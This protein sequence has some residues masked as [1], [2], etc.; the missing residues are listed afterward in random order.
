MNQ[1]L[2]SSMEWQII[3][4]LANLLAPAEQ[5]T[6]LLGGE[7]YTTLA[8]T[9]PIIEEVIQHFKNIKSS[10]MTINNMRNVILNDLISRWSIPN[11]FGTIASFLDPRFKKLTFCS[12]VSIYC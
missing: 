5:A 6:K 8:I 11:N 3:Q 9:I 7:N 12:S 10:N 2:P 1:F 4:G